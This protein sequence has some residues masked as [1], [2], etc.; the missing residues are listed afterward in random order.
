MDPVTPVDPKADLEVSWLSEGT[1]IPID[2]GAVEELRI[3]DRALVLRDRV[4]DEEIRCRW[5]A[6]ASRIGHA[7]LLG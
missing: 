2:S 4:G 5:P 3:A 7:S 1:A 6:I